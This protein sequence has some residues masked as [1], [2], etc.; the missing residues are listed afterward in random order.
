[1]DDECITVENRNSIFEDALSSANF[2]FCEKDK[3][4][5]KFATRYV[6]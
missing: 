6:W 1:M 2:K 5:Y 4:D 3:E